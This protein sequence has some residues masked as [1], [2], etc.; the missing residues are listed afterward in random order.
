MNNLLLEGMTCCYLVSSKIDKEYCVTLR[1]NGADNHRYSF[2]Q[3][4]KINRKT[5][6][7]YGIQLQFDNK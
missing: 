6:V 1:N 3:Q 4:K 5:R 2:L 7:N